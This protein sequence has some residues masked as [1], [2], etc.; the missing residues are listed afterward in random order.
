MVDG[1][2]VGV[3]DRRDACRRMGQV[4]TVARRARTAQGSDGQDGDH[5]SMAA[6]EWHRANLRWRC[7]GR[8]WR[9]CSVEFPCLCHV[10]V[11]VDVAPKGWE[12]G[13]AFSGTPPGAGQ[14]FYNPK[15]FD[16]G[17]R[18]YEWGAGGALLDGLRCR[19]CNLLR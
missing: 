4:P 18:T 9:R 8:R 14:S 2:H 1:V 17:V 11:S 15:P 7:G 19:L 5:G 13:R 6:L 3:D 10:P 16:E 12:L